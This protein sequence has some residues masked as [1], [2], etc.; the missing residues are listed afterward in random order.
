[1]IATYHK[2]GWNL[3]QLRQGVCNKI[4][5]CHHHVL[6]LTSVYVLISCNMC[7]QL[8]EIAVLFR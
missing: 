4:E 3:R 8:A 6:S 7:Y 5:Y 2:L 1:M